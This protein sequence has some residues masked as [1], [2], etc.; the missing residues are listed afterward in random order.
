MCKLRFSCENLVAE[1][2][3]GALDF[4]EKLTSYQPAK[5]VCMTMAG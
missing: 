2:D 3:A 1:A 5:N 4:A